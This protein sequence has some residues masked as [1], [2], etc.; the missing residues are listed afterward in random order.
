MVLGVDP[1]RKWALSGAI[2]EIS[3]G[4]LWHN[5]CQYAVDSGASS[6]SYYHKFRVLSIGSVHL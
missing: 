3:L 1:T 6:I 4:I 5:L 2:S